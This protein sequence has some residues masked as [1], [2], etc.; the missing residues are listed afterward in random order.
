MKVHNLME[1][2]VSQRVDSIYTQM[3]KGKQQSA[4]LTCDCARC[5]MDATAY[6]LN[7]VAPHYIVSGRGALYTSQ[8]LVDSQLKADV[9]ALILEA[10]RTVSSTQ[11]PNHAVMSYIDKVSKK[12]INTPTFNFPIINGV[13]LNGATFEPLVNATVVLMGPEG[14][15]I[16]QDSSFGN[17]CKTFNSTK[18]AFSF[19]PQAE[20]AEKVG[21]AKA[22]HY[23]V[24]AKAEGFIPAT[25]GF[26]IAVTSDDQQKIK[27]GSGLTV[28]VPDL[29]LFKA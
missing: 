5:R 12:D 24:E 16:M 6:V 11:R 22:F 18:G 28:K 10:I 2:Y 13:V 25:V 7:K 9:D 21:I 19:W 17:P 26:D 29:I 8:E 14:S 4:W 23:T 3:T 20:K 1:E 15:V 27:F